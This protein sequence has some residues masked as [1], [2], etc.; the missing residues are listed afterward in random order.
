VVGRCHPLID[1]GR[2]RRLLACH[3]AAPYHLIENARHDPGIASPID[4]APSYPCR[5]IRTNVEIRATARSENNR[6]GRFLEPD[7]RT[8]TRGLLLALPFRV[9][10]DASRDGVK[11]RFI[12]ESGTRL[13]SVLEIERGGAMFAQA[14]LRQALF[15]LRVQVLGSA[16]SQSTHSVERL[17]VVEFDGAALGKPREREVCRELGAMLT[18]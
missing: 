14:E 6:K 18:R 13:V 8:A 1:D 15:D 17:R 9:S 2:V 16:E 11:V 7:R 3:G 10:L 12:N 5:L 4:R